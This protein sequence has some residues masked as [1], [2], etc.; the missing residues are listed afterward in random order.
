MR[1]LRQLGARVDAEF[2]K[3]VVHVRLDRVKR[4]VQL[5]RDGAIRRTLRNEVDDLELRIGEAVPAR[6]GARPAD[7]ASFDSQLAHLA[8]HPASTGERLEV[9]VSV[10]CCI[11]VIKRFVLPTG[12][13][14]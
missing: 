3:Y 7:H 8:A 11:E 2:G 12:D 5:L 13:G 4:E 6:L 14:E 10:E 9:C 1:H